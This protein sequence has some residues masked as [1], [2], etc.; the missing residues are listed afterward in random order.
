MVSQFEHKYV[1]EKSWFNIP[2]LYHS[3]FSVEL[4]LIYFFNKGIKLNHQMYKQKT[5]G[6]QQ[7]SSIK[8]LDSNVQTNNLKCPLCKN[9]LKEPKILT[10]LHVFCKQ[11][12]I[13]YSCQ[14]SD[15]GDHN[16]SSINCPKC[17]QE[18]PIY[19]GI[20]HLQDDHIMEN[21]LDM[22]G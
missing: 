17:K 11:C 7:I 18:T 8:D 12:L 20:D 14:M 9:K 2:N 1:L 15:C 19:E 22:T 4:N 10:C 16:A 13:A 6:S 3:K 21:L 5:N